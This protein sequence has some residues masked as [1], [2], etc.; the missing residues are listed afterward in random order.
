M[1]PAATL[2]ERSC[3]ILRKGVLPPGYL[4]AAA[5]RE[6]A[7][8]QTLYRRGD[9][10]DMIF[11][12]ERGRLRFASATNDGRIIPLYL[13]CAGEYVSEADLFTD[14]H[15][16]DVLAEAH[17]RVIALPKKL[18]LATFHEN[19]AFAAELMQ[20]LTERFNLLRVRL[21]IRNLHSARDR[22]LEYLRLMA[23]AGKSSLMLSRPLRCMADDLGLSHEAFYRTF[24]A[25]VKEGTITR[26]RNCI[27]F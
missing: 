3:L 13:I 18:I 16:G 8:G 10:A 17:S 25:L 22:I 15:C 19:S 5:H 12:V 20:R 26:G 2:S 11:A 27:S 4:N 9:P 21:E 1:T 6:L 23:P 14:S 7:P 24:T